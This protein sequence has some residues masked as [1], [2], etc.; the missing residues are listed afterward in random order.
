MPAGATPYKTSWRWGLANIKR[1]DKIMMGEL[2]VVG[3]GPAVDVTTGD[4]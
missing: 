1:V 2:E 3:I 4:N